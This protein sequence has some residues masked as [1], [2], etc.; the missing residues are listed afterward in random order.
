[1][2]PV[3]SFG[4]GFQMNMLGM[5]ATSMGGAFT[6]FGSDAST[7]FY[8]PGA[9][10][11]REYSQLALGASV[12][13]KS[14]SYL[15]PYAGNTDMKNGVNVPLHFYAIGKLNETTA[16]GISV[17]TPFNMQ[18]EWDDNWT[19]RYI[20]RKTKL[21][22]LY[23]Q[24]SIAYQFTET[25]GIGGGPVIAF[26]TTK[27]TRAIPVTS[28]S[29][30]TALE[31]DGHST[32][33]GFNLGL[34][35]KASDDFTLGLDYR[36]AVKMNVKKG[37]AGFSNVPASL[38]ATYPAS[39]KFE[40][41]YTLPSVITAGAAYKLTRE[42]TLCADINYTTWKSFDSLEFKFENNSQLNYVSGRYYKNVFAFRVGA[43]YAISE[44]VDVRGGVA[45]DSSPVPDNHVVPDNPDN[46]RYIFSAGG[47]MKFGEH[48]SV[49]LAYMLQNVK[50]REVMNEQYNFSGNYKS[51]I[52]I[53]GFTLNYQF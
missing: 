12:I 48:V 6:G 45:F 16:V 44:R 27:M 17:N 22:A 8:N 49:D 33:F 3:V 43:Q 51:I 46:D 25:F 21:K 52:N 1:M 24:P 29:G 39:L 30:E 53:F 28:A 15:S 40:T 47:S 9:M 19:G 42:L 18:A 7:T 11:F 36:S 34:F 10:T 32:G 5:K 23:V 2:I 14:T 4:G 20:A 38:V 37:D 26:G 35:F 31:I 13:H 41:S 50:E